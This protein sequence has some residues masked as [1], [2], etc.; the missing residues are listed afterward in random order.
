M[1]L[2]LPLGQT[3]LA[4]QQYVQNIGDV[5]SQIN[6]NISH[7]ELTDALKSNVCAYVARNVFTVLPFSKRFEIIS[8]SFQFTVNS[9]VTTL[10]CFTF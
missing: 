5:W 7:F 10:H 3:K 1:H 8:F 9:I 4:Y 6:M 2:N